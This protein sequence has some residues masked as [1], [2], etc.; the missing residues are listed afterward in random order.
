MMQPS[1][2]SHHHTISQKTRPQLK[3]QTASLTSSHHPGLRSTSNCNCHCH[4]TL[5]LRKQRNLKLPQNNP[6]TEGKG[7]KKPLETVDSFDFSE[8]S[9]A[10]PACL[11]ADPFHPLTP[12]T[13]PL[14][15]YCIFSCVAI[16]DPV[17][18]LSAPSP[19]IHHVPNSQDSPINVV[20]RRARTWQISS[21][22]SQIVAPILRAMLMLNLAL[23]YASSSVWPAVTRS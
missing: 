14:P 11:S 20:T 6:D 4:C 16:N 21:G 1:H 10:S 22:T 19:I 8:T 17:V 3:I 13:A 15:V 23:R 9:P 12:T 7:Q 18:H 2:V 5:P